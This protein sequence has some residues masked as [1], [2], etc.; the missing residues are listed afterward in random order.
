MVAPAWAVVFWA[1][2]LGCRGFLGGGGGVAEFKFSSC[3]SREKINLTPWSVRYAQD[4][5]VNRGGFLK[6]VG[7][8]SLAPA[9]GSVYA[10]AQP[11]VHW[12]LASS[13][14]NNLDTLYGGAEDLAARVA[15]LTGGRF[16]N[17]GLPGGGD[18][19]R[20]SGVGCVPAGHGGSGAHLGPFC[21]GKSP[22]LAFDGGVPFGLTYRQQN[23]WMLYGGGLELLRAVYAEFGL[24]NFPGGNTG[25]Q[26]G[27]WFRKEIKGFAGLKG[28]RMRIPGLG[29]AAMS[30]L[31]V[32]PQTL[33][34][35]DIYPALERGTI[36]A[37]EFSG[38]YDDERLG[39]Y[40]V[41]PYYTTIP[42]PSGNP[43]RSSPFWS[44]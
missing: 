17:P 34:V 33:A 5:M 40:K 20:R 31:G 25:T 2:P 32:V 1:G 42:L 21:V 27:G 39:F 11:Q 8:G 30:R 4:T 14:P 9:L 37:A 22:V 16:Q 43:R 3:L 28:I 23:A 38:P 10:Q 15:E 24:L 7:V 26:M 29:G 36:D 6:A 12:H 35:R 19:L 41:P 44:T 13:Y 18:R